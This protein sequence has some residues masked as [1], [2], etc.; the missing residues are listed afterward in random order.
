M[1][2]IKGP[3]ILYV[4]AR[5]SRPDIMDEA[6][7]MNWYDNDHIAEIIETSGVDSAFRYKREGAEWP[8]LAM[9]EMRDIAFTQGEEFRKI[10]VYSDLLPGTKLCYDLADNN[11]RY[12]RL[13][14]V[15]DPTNKGPGHTKTLISAQY[16]LKN[17]YSAGDFDAWYRKEHLD[18]LSTASG[19]LRTT[20]FKLV[21][22]RSNAQSRALKGLPV[23]SNEP[24]PNPPTFLALH[25]FESEQIDLDALRAL[26]DTEW[27]RKVHDNTE[28][29]LHP[30]YKIVKAHGKGEWFHRVP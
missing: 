24:Q 5:I 14:Q 30:V 18:Q 22:S 21:F 23:T 2:E 29:V 11:V 6:T 27:T 16:E 9:Y 20:R 12:Y 3:G 13:E 1:A 8:Y 10:R 15:Y 26:T 4:E 19:Y 7:Y 17:G 25:E 28:T